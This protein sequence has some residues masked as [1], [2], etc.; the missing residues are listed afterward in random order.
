MNQ[1][2]ASGGSEI[3]TLVFITDGRHNPASSSKY[4]RTA[5]PAWP[6][7]KKEAGAVSD[8]RG[9]RLAVFGWGL[10]GTGNTDIG[11][12]QSVFPQAQIID[13][14]D[15]QVAGFLASLADDAQRQRV[16]PE[17]A[18]DLASPV[19]AALTVP[20]RL[21]PQTA[22]ELVVTNPRQG[23]PTTAQVDEL[24]VTEPDGTVVPSDLT[25]QG[26]DARARRERHHPGRSPTRR[27]RPRH[28]LGL[29]GRRT[30]VDG[31]RTGFDI[32]RRRT[33]PRCWPRNSAPPGTRPKAAWRTQR[34]R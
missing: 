6:A 22:A 2:A 16:R 33:S 8:A 19:S 26:S 18:D 32:T 28:R 34:Q 9:D 25:P 29:A 24:V 23:L 7:L 30:R 3:Q 10:G 27:R 17:V 15:R 14:P 1:L 12:V 13:L 4:P 20:G 21:Q 5:G 31:R 11:L